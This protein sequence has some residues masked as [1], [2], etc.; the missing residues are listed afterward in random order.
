MEP[1][2]TALE[3]SLADIPERG[4]L[5]LYFSGIVQGWASGPFSTARPRNS[6]WRV[7][8][9]HLRRRDLEVE[10]GRLPEFVRYIVRNA[11]PLSQIETLRLKRSRSTEFQ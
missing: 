7:R 1:R 8:Q 4:R 5:R 9:E 2:K 6:S 11:P 3:V 10:G